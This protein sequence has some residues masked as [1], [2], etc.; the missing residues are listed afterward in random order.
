VALVAVIALLG[1]ALLL[2]ILGL[3][4][5]PRDKVAV[6]HSTP[7]DVDYLLQ[8][9]FDRAV[10]ELEL[11]GTD[12]LLTTDDGRQE[13]RS[14]SEDGNRQIISFTSDV[15]VVNEV[16]RAFP[17]TRYVVM[18]QIGLEPNVTY[19]LFDDHESSFLA[20]AAAALKT[21]TRTIGF[22][23]GVDVDIIWRFQAGYEA[24][25]RAVDPDITILSDYLSSLPDVSGFNSPA[26]GRETA[27][28]MYRKGAD[29]VLLAAGRSSYGGFQAA[30]EW[31]GRTSA[32]VWVIGV[33]SDQYEQV[34]LLPGV[35]DEEAWRRHI[36]TS[37]VKRW[38]RAVYAVLADHVRGALRPGVTS[39]DLE[40]G[41]VDISYSGGFID[42]IRPRLDELR[43]Q[44]VSGRLAVP[45][46]PA[47]KADEAAAQGV[48]PSCRR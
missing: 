43:A 27:G 24:G 16:A 34:A 48:E 33:D 7:G 11:V 18:D 8:N 6:V 14:L 35:V 44:I 28:E 5:P 2:A 39:L 42:D 41:G 15:Q 31:S 25:A 32:Q 47:E 23:G 22:V 29:V 38:D 17:D 9:G 1:G 19:V 20:G 40:S 36:L 37:V 26:A 30:T 45:C 46:V 21:R 13:L 3:R 12:R 4:T 10:S